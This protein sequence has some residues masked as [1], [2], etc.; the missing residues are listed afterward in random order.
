MYRYKDTTVGKGSELAAALE[1]SDAAAKHVYENT[2][3]AFFKLYGNDA[4]WF[5]AKHREN[6]K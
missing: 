4:T 2:T 5:I 1:R 6:F 3:E